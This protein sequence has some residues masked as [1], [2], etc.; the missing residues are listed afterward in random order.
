MGSGRISRLA[1]AERRAMGYP[2][3]L[4]GWRSASLGALGAVLGTGLVA[5]G[6]AGGVQGTAHHVIAHTRQILHAAAA[7]EHDA[8]L[9]QVVA[10]ARDVGRAFDAVGEANAGHLAKGRVRLLRGGGEHTRTHATLL[11]AGVER[12]AL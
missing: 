11:R 1:G 8:V 6:D 4:L 9:L 3:L 10:H 12:W 2:L 5:A 7:D